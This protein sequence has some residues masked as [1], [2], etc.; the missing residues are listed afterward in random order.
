MTQPYPHLGF[1]PAPGNIAAVSALQAK[2]TSLA[3]TLAKAYRLV[4]QLQS[5]SSWEGDAA[6]AF[7]EELDG[8]LPDN[9]KKAHTSLL[10][11]A[12]ALAGWS[13][14]LHGYLGDAKK[15]DAEAKAAH[16]KLDLAKEQEKKASNNPDLKLAHQT[17]T[18]AASLQNAQARLD[19][20]TTAL[21]DARGSVIDAQGLLSSI[22]RRAHDLE[23]EHS[24]TARGK[25][26]SIRDA[27]DKLAPKE[28]G[29]FGKAM[30]WLDDNL[31][32][33]LGTVAAIAGLLALVLSGPI[34]VAFLLVA[35]T[36]SAATL[37]SRLSDPAV[38]AS[39]KDG[40][41]K[42]EFDAGFWSNAVGVA[43]DTLGMVPGVGAVARGINGAV[44]SAG[45]AT[46]TLTLTD[47][48]AS[49]GSKT[50]LAANRIAGAEN[51]LTTWVVRGA[52]NPERAGRMIDLGVTGAGTATGTYG[53]A[54]DLIDTLDDDTANNVGTS[55]DGVR[56]GSFDGAGHGAT[57]LKTLQVLLDAGH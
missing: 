51:P 57:A 8:A 33:V 30:D 37:A 35:A 56:A 10:K 24:S 54:K 41:T 11:A 45:A 43:G 5:G 42:G 4:Q 44:R 50:W 53:T 39:L 27:T 32:D 31:T 13:R 29:W 38:R 15:L 28:P 23:S 20:A 34:G 14:A 26:S 47:H 9:L 46:G 16:D 6:V 3:E 48:L 17:F 7:R 40:F 21:N 52:A 22:K 25:A 19:K 55:M 49:A 18:D 2:L 36:A 12:D 1:D